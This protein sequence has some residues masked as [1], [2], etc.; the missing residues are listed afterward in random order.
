MVKRTSMK[1]IALAGPSNRRRMV[2]Q[3]ERRNWC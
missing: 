2:K 3:H 1:V